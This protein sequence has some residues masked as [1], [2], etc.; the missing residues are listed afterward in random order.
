MTRG[1]KSSKK[2]DSPGTEAPP[3][4]KS[5]GTREDVLRELEA[6]YND[7]AMPLAKKLDILKTIGS[8]KH[9]MFA[10]KKQIAIDIRSLVSRMSDSE[11]RQIAEGAAKEAV[12]EELGD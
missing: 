5:F 3:Q 1:T 6:L 4:P 8:E 10:D 7:P 2:P 11:V 12:A 9:R